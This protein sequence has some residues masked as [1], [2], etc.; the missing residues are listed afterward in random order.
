MLPSLAKRG[1]DYEGRGETHRTWESTR[2]NIIHISSLSYFNLLQDISASSSTL[3]TTAALYFHSLRSL[4]FLYN[5]LLLPYLCGL[6]SEQ[7]SASGSITMHLTQLLL[8]ASATLTLATP[9]HSWRHHSWDGEDDCTAEEESPSSTSPAGLST[10]APGGYEAPTSV[11]P[12]ST[13]IAPAQS[14]VP[15]V[16]PAPV[17]PATGVSTPATPASAST[18]P[19]VQ[20]ATS[21]ATAAAPPS[22]SSAAS[23]P[24]PSSSALIATFTEYVPFPHHL[25][26]QLTNPSP[27]Y[28]AGDSFGSPNCNTATAACGFYTNPGYNA[29]ASQALYGAG[30]GAGAGSACGLCYKLTALTNPYNNDAALSAAGT[31]IVVK[32]NNLCPADGN[33]LC[34][35]GSLS[36]TNTLGM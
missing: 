21:S 14:S 32:V 36:D 17:G 24:P 10:T 5:L 33:P 6:R 22:S 15:P 34:A 2:R 28:G 25:P 9:Y 29:A 13:A 3:I 23:A 18:A 8:L 16:E 30:P 1:A 20:A 11:P 7:N 31:S 19:P 35:Q 26:I 4:S 27:R 12:N